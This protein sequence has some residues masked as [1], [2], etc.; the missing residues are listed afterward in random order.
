MT[1]IHQ[2][3]LANH[4]SIDDAS[5]HSDDRNIGSDAHGRQMPDDRTPDTTSGSVNISFNA[6]MRLR[7]YQ[8]QKNQSI[9]APGLSK[10]GVMTELNSSIDVLSDGIAKQN[11]NKI[12]SDK[13]HNDTVEND[14][15]A[16]LNH[17]ADGNF[18]ERISGMLSEVQNNIVQDSEPGYL[19]LVNML[20]NYQTTVGDPQQLQEVM[21]KEEFYLSR[22]K[23]FMDSADFQSYSQVLNQFSNIVERQQY[24]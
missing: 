16:L 5:H 21:R 6:H 18:S 7:A 23:P 24:A 10:Q 11:L 22:R 20:N 3:A 17:T 12:K 13:I 4:H 9:A 1:E 19:Y 15:S 14:Y 8:D 2:N